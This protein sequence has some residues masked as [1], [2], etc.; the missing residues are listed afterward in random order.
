MKAIRIY[1]AGFLLLSGFIFSQNIDSLQNVYRTYYETKLLKTNSAGRYAVLNHH[2]TYGK[3]EDELIDLKINKVTLLKKHDFYQFLDDDILFMRNKDQCRF[4]NVKTGQYIDINGHFIATVSKPYQKVVLY[5]TD[6]KI[7]MTIS[8]EAK[9]LWKEDGVSKY[10]LNDTSGQLIYISDHQLG[11]TDMKDQ[12]SKTFKL[13][14]TVQWISCKDNAVYCADIQRSVITLYSVDLSSNQLIQRVITSPEGFEFVPT[15]SGFF[16]I[17][18]DEHFLFPMYL[19]S[20]FTDKVNPELK[21]TYSN[22]NSR[23]KNLNRYLGIYNIKEK[24]WE[25]VP[26]D[27]LQLPVYEFLNDKGD[28][29]FYDQSSNIIE[30]DPNAVLDL[31]LVL[32]YGKKNHILPQKRSDQVNYLWDRNTEQFIYFDQKRWKSF[33]LKTGNVKELMPPNTTGWES[34]GHNGLGNNPELIPI[35]VRNKPIILFSNQY[36]Y[37]TLDLRTNE[38]KRIT[39][40]EEKSVKYKLVNVKDQNPHSSWS[41]KHSE[42]DLEK[43]LIFKLFNQLNYHSGF[44]EY[45]AKNNKTVFY[46]QQNYKEMIPYDKGLL[47]TSDFALEPFKLTRFENGKYK[48][49]YDALKADKEDLKKM[50]YEIFQY[51]TSYGL[52]NAAVLFPMGYDKNKRYP[53]IVNI[54]EK[55]SRD[56]L[57]FQPPYLTASVG[58]NYLHYLMNGYVVLLPDLKYETGNT[59]NS[60]LNSLEKSIDSAKLLASVDDKNIGIAGLSYGGYETG[61]AL[62]NS[63]YF[64]TGVAGVMVSDLVSLTLSNSEMNPTPNYMRVENQQ[65]RMNSNVFDDWKNYREHSPVYYLKSVETPVLIWS[66]LKDKNVSPSQSRMFFLGLKRLKKKAVLLEYV[67]ESHNILQPGNQLDL[68]VKMW[69]WFDYHLKNKSPATWINPVL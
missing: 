62:G 68:N 29:I 26:D 8:K 61:M 51:Q 27:R 15:L 40:G 12:K 56:L 38:V 9:I 3:D 47:F 65:F 49:V 5:D 36:D 33:N 69:Q 35:R 64:K 1:I 17:R 37:F 32:D 59:K 24:Q 43:D 6:S 52:S 50:S 25:Y 21:I 14:N 55:Q 46:S 54:Y 42:I 10:Q 48:V 30:A 23:N 63:K 44:A 67:N 7:L 13:D 34:N 28:F 18:E 31:K 2:N 41:I 53:M 66:G 22:I 11:I 16:E 57:Y 39:K 45:S 60:M 58:F 4:L 20:K 19:K